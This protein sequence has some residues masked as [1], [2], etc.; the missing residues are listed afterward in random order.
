LVEIFGK[1]GCPRP[2]KRDHQ[3]SK[4]EISKVL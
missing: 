3:V 1:C 2:F 4:T